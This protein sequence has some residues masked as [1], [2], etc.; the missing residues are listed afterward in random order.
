MKRTVRLGVFET[1][2][3]TTHR[4]VI[5]TKKQ[6]D[7]WENGRLLYDEWEEEFVTPEKGKEK[8]YDGGD[9]DDQEARKECG[10]YTYDDFGTE[11]GY[12]GLE[13]D[14]GTFTTPSGDIVQ[15]E[16]AYGYDY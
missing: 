11:Y 8:M 15:W 5:G 7:D 16:A 12:Y 4:L 2:S 14:W 6:F 3:S 1:N 10:L 9:L 13:H